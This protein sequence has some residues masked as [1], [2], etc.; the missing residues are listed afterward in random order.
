M[1]LLSP[2]KLSMLKR[3]VKEENIVF[4]FQLKSHTLSYIDTLILFLVLRVGETDKLSHP[5]LAEVVLELHEMQSLVCDKYELITS[6]I[7]SLTTCPLKEET[8]T[9][10][11]KIIQEIIDEFS[12]RE[13][14]NLHIWVPELNLQ[15]ESIFVK[16]L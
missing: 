16:R 6:T 10:K 9:E 2:Y 11:L 8:L 14:S 1:E 12:K 3:R 7:Q 5:F 15:L 13:V 4:R